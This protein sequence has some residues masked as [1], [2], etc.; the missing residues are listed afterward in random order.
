MRWL[1]AGRAAIFLALVPVAALL[2]GVPVAGELYSNRKKGDLGPIEVAVT[3]DKAH[4][5][6]CKECVEKGLEARID[7]LRRSLVLPNELDETRREKLVEIAEK[8]FVRRTLE[9]SGTVKTE[10]MD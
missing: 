3:H 10:L 2:I 6:N 1:G 4:A 7:R 5:G 8:C 9:A